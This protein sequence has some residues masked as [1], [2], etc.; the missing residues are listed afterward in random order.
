MSDP[1]APRASV[2]SRR[3]L[4]G[5]A[6][7][8]AIVAG[9]VWAS[10]ELHA[11]RTIQLFGD[12]V[13]S[14]ATQDSVVALTFDDGP[15]EAYTDSILE[16]LDAHQVPVTFFV[17]G[18]SVQRHPAL[19]RRMVARGHQLGNHSFSHQRMIL[20]GQAFY[21]DEVER[22]DS[23]IRAAGQ[24][25]AVPFRPP[26]GNRLLG[27]PWYLRKTGRTTVLWSIEPDTWYRQADSMAAH[28]LQRVRPGAI[29][30]LHVEIS[31]RGEGRAAL[32]AIIEGVRA[33]GYRFVTVADL[34]DRRVMARP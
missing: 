28:V 9:L 10:W 24:T 12:F 34:L 14:V 33:K 22:T 27:L 29:I 13:P 19:A 23:L 5:A 17:I 3:V 32:P 4:T 8:C 1:R 20:H 16:I 25:G 21:R 7:A 2:R 31:S 18:E 15:V 26:F 30:L 11:S 6:F